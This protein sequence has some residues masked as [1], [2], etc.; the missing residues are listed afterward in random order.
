MPSNRANLPWIWDVGRMTRQVA[1][2]DTVI[3]A[4]IGCEISHI[5]RIVNPEGTL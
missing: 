4:Q 5:C 1:R 2:E 3:R